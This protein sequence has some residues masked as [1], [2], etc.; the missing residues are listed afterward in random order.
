MYDA[1]FYVLLVTDAAAVG[2]AV[3]GHIQVAIR[4]HAAI[5]KGFIIENLR[6]DIAPIQGIHPTN[7]NRNEQQL[8]INCSHLCTGMVVGD[9]I[10][11][12]VAQLF[13]LGS[14]PLHNTLKQISSTR[15][16]N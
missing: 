7:E 2:V 3:R 10:N 4:Q 6:A 11:K 1:V 13:D 8:C 12:M 9:G 15:A 5:R 16:L 14:I